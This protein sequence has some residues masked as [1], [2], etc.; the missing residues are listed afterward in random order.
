MDQIVR[1]RPVSQATLLG[2][3]FLISAISAIGLPPL[4]GFLGKA[5]LLHST[6]RFEEQIWVWPALLISSLMVL[7]AFSRAGSTFFWHVFPQAS[8]G[9]PSIRSSQLAAI[10]ILLSTT[11]LMTVFADSILTYSQGAASD[12][13][14]RTII[15]QHHTPTDGSQIHETHEP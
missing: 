5:L 4:S 11:V 3:M 12:V 6:G 15:M 9:D 2:W 1:A 10:S 8:S 7:V 13:R 14:K